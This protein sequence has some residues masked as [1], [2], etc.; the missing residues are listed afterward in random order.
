VHRDASAPQL[1]PAA[2][3]DA[4]ARLDASQ[5]FRSA[6]RHRV[7][8]HHLVDRLAAGDT[9]A[10]KESVLAVQ[11]F[12]RPA[13]GF[14]PVRDSIVRVEARRLRARLAAYHAGEG[15]LAP[16]RI[17]L[18]VGSYVPVLVPA[19]GQPQAVEATRRARDLVERGDYFLRQPLSADSLQAARARF[20][21]ALHESP[22]SAAACVGLART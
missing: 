22:Q 16:L 3:Q 14:D 17:E 21:A 12:G 2:W 1:Q 8:L 9:A 18:P 7:L 19:P 4:L 6:R 5:A 15:R 13:A 10:L 20:E 11:V